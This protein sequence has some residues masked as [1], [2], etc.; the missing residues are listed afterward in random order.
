M[1]LSG[2]ARLGPYEIL[3]P[4]G[5]GGMGEVY[6][7]RDTKL[8]REVAVKVLSENLARDP[9]A[10]ARFEREA[11]AV[12]AL[13]HPNILAVHDFGQSDGT[14]YAV[15]ELL[16]GESLRQRLAEGPLPQKKAV[17]IAREI[18]L[19]V[20]A[21]ADKG[22]VHRDLKPE[23]LFLT[24]DGRVK[25][26]DFG[27]ARQVV[28]PSGSDTHSP[29][30]V[31]VSEPGMV[32]GTAGYMS[33]E[34]LRGQPADSRSDIFSLGAVL[35]EM[36]AGRRA[37][38]GDTAIE[39]MNA[40]LK[41]DPPEL[42]RP[43]RPIAPALARIVAHCLEKRPEDRFQSARDLA[44]DLGSVSTISSATAPTTAAGPAEAGSSRRRRFLLVAGIGLAA[45]ALAFWAGARLPFRADSPEVRFRRL[46]FH[47]GNVLTARF[48]PDG[49]TVVYGAA[50]E[51]RPS[52][53][54]SVRTDS[55]ESRALGL[56]QATVLSVS[57]RGE[58]AVLLR[59]GSFQRSSSGTLARVS[60]GG[61]AARELQENVYSAQWA[62]DGEEMAIVRSA[63]DGKNRLEYPVG[64]PL[65]D[66]FGLNPSIAVS[67]DGDSVVFA[68]TDEIGQSSIWTVDKRGQKRLITRGWWDFGSL[69]MSARTGEVYFIARTNSGSTALRA[70]SLSGR[71]RVVWPGAQGYILH[72]IA[73]DGRVLLERFVLREGLIWAGA[74]APERELG[75]LDGTELRDLSPDG[76]QILFT[77]LGEGADRNH[78]A[79]IR[80][81]DG[82]PAVRLGDGEPY[83]LSPDGKWAL[84]VTVGDSPEIVLLPTGPGSPRKISVKSIRPGLAYFLGDGKRILILYIGA[85]N[86]PLAAVVGLDGGSAIPVSASSVNASAGYTISRD[87]A[88]FAYSTATRTIMVASLDGGSARPV[89]GPGLQPRESIVDWSGDGR[90]VIVQTH[91]VPAQVS[92][93]DAR[94]GDHT[95]WT[96]VQPTDR[97]GVTA[98]GPIHFTRDGSG[99][100]YS[101]SRA[102]ASDV[103]VVDG[104]R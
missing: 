38:G 43:D 9:A 89:P 3:S 60:I 94:T 27:L 93:I 100:A 33:P 18:A 40:I 74:G 55:V 61:G 77:E 63:P 87:G 17:D 29:T 23:N 69:V 52:A 22:I 79:Y 83:S 81:T 41:E 53:L 31:H 45:I 16:E 102:V 72:D 84:T 14:T 64:H 25:I 46:T 86:A 2:G 35:Y 75:W 34:Q 80:G 13:S 44:F 57:S 48:A 21:A 70:V 67:R 99:R 96:Q 95:P 59:K 12:A 19:G 11:K 103:Y 42:S 85:D 32:L 10:L 92:R 65:H 76:R 47:R 37:F 90:F 7:A 5:A 71:M 51:G 78:G 6:R 101:Y 98:V 15:M 49:Q 66:S 88:S 39:A 24:A 1:S 30:A 62:P 36:L 28:L 97:A 73:P 20:A 91:D 56:D 104:L 26:L 8:D 54:F 82:S 50:W 58:L 68:D 4:L